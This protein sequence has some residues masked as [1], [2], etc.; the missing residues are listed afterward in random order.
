M[1]VL[2]GR[3][4]ARPKAV[5]YTPKTLAGW[6]LRITAGTVNVAKS[7]RLLCIPY[8]HFSTMKLRMILSKGI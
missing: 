8:I 1:S 7:V 2:G 4:D 6:L 3:I 5:G